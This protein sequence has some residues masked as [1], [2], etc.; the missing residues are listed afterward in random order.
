M[1]LINRLLAA[2][3]SLAL[4]VAGV[5]VVVE[6]VAQ[7]LGRGPAIVDWPQ[8]HDWVRRTPWQ[9]GSVRV[10]SILLVLAGLV[11]LAA[12]LRRGRPGR[13]A[14]RSEVTDAAYTRRGVAAAI[15][16]A[17]SDV[18]GITSATVSVSRRKVTVEATTAGLQPYTAAGLQEP[19]TAAARQRL[20]ALELREP[21]ALS[22]TVN[23]ATPVRSS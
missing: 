23:T 11:L 20:D 15:R 17:V 7:R 4:I 22:V 10:A 3:L 8:L 6:V 13:L 18:D 14:V 2:L 9:Q 19:A 21:P 5:L 12:E 1:R 16:S